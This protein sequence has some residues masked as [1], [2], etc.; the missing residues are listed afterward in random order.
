MDCYDKEF[1]EVMAFFERTIGKAVR[2]NGDFK[3][4]PK[5]MWLKAQYYCNGEIN[6]YFRVFLCGYTFHKSCNVLVDED[7]KR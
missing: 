1:Y 6:D 3:K 4:E 2:L 7:Y 5:E